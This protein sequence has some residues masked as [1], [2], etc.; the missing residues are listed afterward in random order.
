MFEYSK[1]KSKFD[2]LPAQCSVA[3]FIEFTKD[4][5]GSVSAEKGQT[6]VCA[7]VSAGLHS[8][9]GKYPGTI[10]HWRQ[11][12]LAKLRK[13]LA[14]DYDGFETPEVRLANKKL[15]SRKIGC[16]TTCVSL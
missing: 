6:Y 15:S 16:C 2:N 9:Q 5:L 14:F 1:G 8:D 12:H 4:V 3:T 11:Q 7:A 10:D 13:F